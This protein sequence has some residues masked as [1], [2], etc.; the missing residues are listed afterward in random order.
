MLDL[1]VQVF[2]FYVGFVC[3]LLLNV[4]TSVVHWH[5]ALVSCPF[6]RGPSSRKPPNKSGLP[7]MNR[8]RSEI[9]TC[10][11]TFALWKITCII[12]RSAR[13]W[14]VFFVGKLNLWSMYPLL[15]FWFAGQESTGFKNIRNTTWMWENRMNASSSALLWGL[16]YSTKRL[17]QQCHPCCR[18]WPWHY[19]AKSAPFPR[20]GHKSVPATWQLIRM[21]RWVGQWCGFT[22]FC[23]RTFTHLLLN[24]CY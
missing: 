21:V 8:Y 13:S 17:R 19:D 3:L 9:I 20:N 14:R 22:V 6:L 16:M 12:V 11:V 4:R 15:V 24:Y 10:F 2:H 18:T 5:A 1:E 23:C 7:V